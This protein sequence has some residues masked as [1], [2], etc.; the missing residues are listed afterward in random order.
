MRLADLPDYIIVHIAG[1]DIGNVRLGYLY[2]LIKRFLSW[3]SWQMPGTCIIWSQ[4]LPRLHWRYSDNNGAMERCR[5]RLNSSIGAMVT[6]CGGCYIRY[7]DIRAS[8]TF[9]KDD[10]VHLT[11]IGNR[12]LLNTIQ[13]ALETIIQTSKGGLTFPS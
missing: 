8:D 1:N 11:K 13:G 3:L 12:I 5:A 6:K 4:I 7:P 2:F 9:L 10:G